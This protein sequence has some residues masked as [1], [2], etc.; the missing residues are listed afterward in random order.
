MKPKRSFVLGLGVQVASSVGNRRRR[1]AGLAA[2]LLVLILVP[3][4]SACGNPNLSYVFVDGDHREYSL[5][6]AVAEKGPNGETL[7]TVTLEALLRADVNIDKQHRCACFVTVDYEDVKISTTGSAQSS[8]NEIPRA[9]FHLCEDRLLTFSG[10]APRGDNYSVEL[11]RTGPNGSLS[12]MLLNTLVGKFFAQ[13]RRDSLHELKIGNEWITTRQLPGGFMTYLYGGQRPTEAQSWETTQAEV[14]G[15]TGEGAFA[16]LAWSSVTPLQGSRQ[17]DL[18]ERLLESGMDPS[19]IAVPT[20]DEGE[21]T[22]TMSGSSNCSG[23]AFV[24]TSDG[25][26]QRASV[27]RMT[28]DLTSSWGY[29]DGLSG[30]EEMILEITGSIEAIS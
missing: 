1:I 10:P 25:W 7:G 20:A 29:S 30:A 27:D 3:L 14:T 22:M 16:E 4:I 19:E 13:P 12:V 2:V 11:A 18:T 26:P 8:G 21:T 15:T 9:Y 6:M 5:S 28:V 17:V 23:T 24:R